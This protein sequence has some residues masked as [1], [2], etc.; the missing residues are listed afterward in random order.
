MKTRKLTSKRSEKLAS[1]CAKMVDARTNHAL[2]YK[3]Y[4]N[5][6]RSY[7]DDLIRL[8]VFVRYAGRELR[9]A[10]S[11]YV[12]FDMLARRHYIKPFGRF[13]LCDYYLSE[14][15]KK[16]KGF[17]IIYNIPKPKMSMPKSLK[18]KEYFLILKGDKKLWNEFRRILKNQNKE[19][20]DVVKVWVERY[21][22]DRK[23]TDE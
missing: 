22:I 2:P 3:C 23:I 6:Q 16:V 15:M 4:I 5:L 21:L 8:N 9:I 19:P 7:K 18:S 14:R 12:L 13:N 20:W 10:L 11:Q 17:K 1:Y